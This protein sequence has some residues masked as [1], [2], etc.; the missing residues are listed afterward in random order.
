MF[1]LGNL[2]MLI[3]LHLI[4]VTLGSLTK[5]R[6]PLSNAT[7]QQTDRRAENDTLDEGIPE[8]VLLDE[9]AQ[10]EEHSFYM[11][12]GFEVW[13]AFPPSDVQLSRAFLEDL[14]V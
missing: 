2:C 9:N 11:V 8:E 1:C 12:G 6:H 3:H 13:H 4:Y 14:A 10:A 5:L 7:M